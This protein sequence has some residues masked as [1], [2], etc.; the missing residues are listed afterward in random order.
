MKFFLPKIVLFLISIS[1]NKVEYEKVNSDKEVGAAVVIRNFVRESFTE[2]GII[3]Y[4]L[5]ADESYVFAEPEK[6]ILYNFVYD[7]YEKGVYNSHLSCNRGDLDQVK[8]LLTLHGNIKMENI[9]NRKLYTE[10]LLYKLDD[11]TLATDSRVLIFLDGTTISG[12]GLRSDSELKK[13]TVL[14]PDA[15]TRDNPFKGKDNK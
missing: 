11:K 12:M 4:H 6:T 2:N 3:N 9:E 1:C 7:Q 15:I 14:H 13:V 8:K 10:D 5:K